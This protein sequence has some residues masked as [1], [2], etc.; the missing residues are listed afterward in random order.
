MIKTS[1]LSCALLAA[2]AATAWAAKLPELDKAWTD[3]C[4]SLRKGSKNLPSVVRN[5]CAC[6]QELIG[7]GERFD[8]V[9]AMERMYPPAHRSCMRKTGMRPG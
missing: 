4:V 8:S 9:A 2:F 5:Y 1:F 7:A 6:M 3:N